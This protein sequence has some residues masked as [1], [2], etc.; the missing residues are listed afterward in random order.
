MSP[1]VH[2]P[3]PVRSAAVVNE[4]IRALVTACGGWL[5]GETR[6]RYERLVAEWTVARARER[7][8]GDVVKAA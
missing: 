5:Y 4:D 7:M 6:A 2:V 8:L 3:G 1:D